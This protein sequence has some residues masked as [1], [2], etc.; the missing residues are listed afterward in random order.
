[1]IGN[2]HEGAYMTHHAIITGTGRSGTTF[3]VE[4]LTAL[5]VD[6]GFDSNNIQKHIDAR[7]GLEI[8]LLDAAS[9][10][11]VVKDPSFMLYLK[12]VLE[13][14]DLV[15]DHVFIALRDVHAASESR[16]Y[17][18]AISN[19]EKYNEGAVPGG[20]TG[21]V[22]PEQQESVLLQ[23]MFNLALQLSE[24]DCAITYLHYPLMIEDS[25]Y[26]YEKLK[27]ILKNVSKEFFDKRFN[28]IADKKL[29][30]KFGEKDV[31]RG[32][33]QFKTDVPIED[34]RTEFNISAQLFFHY[35]KG[36]S[37]KA[38]LTQVVP[39]ST[40][41]L[42]FSVPIN[43][44]INRLRFDPA[45]ECCSIVLGDVYAMLANGDKI[46]LALSE[47]TGYESEGV[48]YFVDNDPQ[49]YFVV[50]ELITNVKIEIQYMDIGTNVK[51]KALPIIERLLKLKTHKLK[52][53]LKQGSKLN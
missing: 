23:R 8:N 11:Y 33:R 1:L 27:P 29:V 30:N 6:T 20:L 40:K 14:R 36:F 34:E 49:L 48:Y 45:N 16:R 44:R 31:T 17:V 10:P 22:A 35:G 46:K 7:A 43:K 18:E 53:I 50:G 28:Q 24:T 52:Q 9:P 4:M 12:D 5:G 38:S 32:F 39:M 13:R 3:L 47:M 51:I 21:T 37:E 25:D 26:L 19:K 41:I 2:L 42:D 15:L